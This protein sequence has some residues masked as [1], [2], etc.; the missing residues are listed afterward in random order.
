M[1]GMEQNGMICEMTHDMFKKKLNRS[2][3]VILITCN[4]IMQIIHVTQ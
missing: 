3:N 4:Q 1:R 2:K